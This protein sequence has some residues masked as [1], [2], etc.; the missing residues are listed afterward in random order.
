MRLGQVR[1][2][3]KCLATGGR[4][5]VETALTC[6]H[7]AEVA[8]VLGGMRGIRD[9][10]ANQIDSRIDMPRTMR[11]HAKQMQRFGVLRLDVQDFTTQSFG[12]GQASAAVVLQRESHLLLCRLHLHARFYG[13][14]SVANCRS[15]SN[16]CLRQ[17]A[18][19][20]APCVTASPVK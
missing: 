12:I 10:A 2:A 14:V 17:T 3:P 15:S 9:G 11:K 13:R 5:V 1:V 19:M 18:A 6:E 4:G 8:V 7:H 16:R 20:L